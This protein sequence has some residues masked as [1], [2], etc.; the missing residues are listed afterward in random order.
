MRERRQGEGP[1]RFVLLTTVVASAALTL[2]AAP[3]LPAETGSIVATVA[4]PAPSAPCLTLNG[5]AVDFGTASFSDPAAPSTPSK[6]GTPAIRV[7]SCTTAPETI[8]AAV[9]DASIS[10]GGSWDVASVTRSN[11]CTFGLN[12]YMA[13]WTNRAGSGRIYNPLPNGSFGGFGLPLA[14]GQGDDVTFS[15][16]MPCRGSVGAGG[17]ASMTFSMLAVLD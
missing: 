5:G 2:G 3:A 16:Q 11:T 7:T 15:I 9:S 8:F 17:T 6:A 1:K 10:T 12:T 14:A 4:V 13:D